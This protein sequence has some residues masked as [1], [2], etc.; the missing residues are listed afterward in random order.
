M[1]L[2]T[3]DIF[4]TALVRRC[5]SPGAALAMVAARRFPGDDAAAAR[6]LSRR[7]VAKGD[8][9]AELYG[10]MGEGEAEMAVEMA[11][12]AATLTVNPAV[13]A[14]IDSLRAE[15][16][17]VK[18]LSDMYLPSAV[19]ADVLRREGCL[20][21]DEEVIVSCEHG[22]RKD[23]GTL[24]E[25]VRSLYAPAEWR[26]YGDNRRS[27]V[28]MARRH[29]VDAHHVA[30]PFTDA[31]RHV[32]SS[33]DYRMQVLA[34]LSRMGRVAS[35]DDSAEARL[36]ADAVVPAY[37][38]FVLHV[39]R[40][41]RS[42]GIGSLYFL[43][44]DGFIMLEMARSL[45]DSGYDTPALEYLYVSRR[46]LL[47]A[48]LGRRE[49][50]ELSACYLRVIDKGTLLRKRV[51][52]LLRGLGLDAGRLS[53]EYGVTFAFDKITTGAQQQE[54]LDK[55]F[56]HPV[57]TPALRQRWDEAFELA[58]AYLRQEGVLGGA[59][60]SAMVDVGWL[61][62]SR[63]M[64][65]DILRRAGGVDVFTY[66]MGVR[67]DVYPASCGDFDSY[68][69]AGELDTQATALIE[70]YFSASPWPSV[71]GYRRDEESGE[72]RPVF[73]NDAGYCATPI[74]KANVAVA[75]AMA[76]EWMLAGVDNDTVLKRWSA[77]ST[78]S[79]ASL[80]CHYDLSPLAAS[81]GIGEEPL[82]SRLCAG[83]LAVM[84]LTGKALT[85]F[86]LA[87]LHY[88]VDRRA[89]RL[90]WPIHRLTGRLRAMLFR[91]LVKR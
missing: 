78:D 15:G 27:D 77:L 86:P 9:L 13:N 70:A 76:R 3:F 52:D 62:T 69:A 37:L 30:T 6:W 10:S 74:V 61:G 40:D 83:E 8:T 87:S 72:I 2:A 80:R 23:T 17:T 90:L 51:G 47:P 5:G 71:V 4:D 41:A 1:R 34:G 65:N 45:S 11:V 38:P 88:T 19:L 16:W 22:A 49:A 36:A 29:G 64:V 44:R 68:F 20:V 50:A 57:L 54:F 48:Y 56:S 7:R 24:Y 39:V 91:I 58:T 43:N 42:R 28:E 46:S 26:H 82:V 59:G 33:A 18:F 81:A 73:K 84:S 89:A 35:G 55:I 12:E 25:R 53:R 79:I 66:Y 32:G 21:G 60:R 75:R 63:L 14:L 85:D 31:E 67:G